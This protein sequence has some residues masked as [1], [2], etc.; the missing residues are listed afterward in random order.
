[1]S[2][3]GSALVLC[4]LRVHSIHFR[5]EFLH[6]ICWQEEKCHKTN[7]NPVE[8]HKRSKA[9]LLYKAPFNNKATQRIWH[10]MATAL[11]DTF[12]Q[13]WNYSPRACKSTHHF[14]SFATKQRCSVL[15]NKWS[16]WGCVLI[17]KKQLKTKPKWLHTPRPAYSKSLDVQRSKIDLKKCC[18][19]PFLSQHF[20]WKLLS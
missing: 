13:K 11:K 8:L 10:E 6:W 15:L 7:I 20:L 14:W 1:M 4:E 12:T 18:F 17:R 2:G 5:F 19:H 16:R 3:C 9:G